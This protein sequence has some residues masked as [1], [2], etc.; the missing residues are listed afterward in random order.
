[1]LP[2]TLQPAGYRDF[3]ML[4]AAHEDRDITTFGQ[5]HQG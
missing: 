4:G 2:S 5:E 3:T 1:M